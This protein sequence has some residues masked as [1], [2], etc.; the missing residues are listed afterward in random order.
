MS[1]GDEACRM[2]KGGRIMKHIY[3]ERFREGYD[4]EILDNGLEVILW[5]KEGYEKS[6]FM[7]V[8][9]F[10][11]RDL[12]QQD[13]QGKRVHHPQG[14]A[15][16]LEHKMF[17]MHG[18][19]IMNRFSAI[20]ANVNAFTSY[21]ET[22]Y[23]AATCGDPREPLNLLLDFV[24]TLDIDEAS[25]AKEKG[26]ILSELH[27]YQEMSDQQLLRET[28]RSLYQKHP[29][30]YDIG[31]D[32]ASVAATTLAQLYRCYEWNYHPSRMILICISGR[33]NDE[34]RQIIQQNQAQKQFAPPHKRTTVYEAEPESVARPYY[35]FTMDVSNPRLCVAY[36]LKG[37]IDPKERLCC[38]WGIRFLL[39]AY[40]SALNPQYQSWIDT[41]VI[42]DYCGCDVDMGADVGSLLFY[43]ETRQQEAFISLCA[44]CMK[45]IMQGEISQP[46]LIQLRKR[47]Y[48]QSIRAMNNFD[49]MA[50]ALARSRFMGTDYFRML[51]DLDHFQAQDVKRAGAWVSDAQRALICLLPQNY[52]S[53][54][55]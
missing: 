43:G 41:G 12:I 27:M 34:L 53:S 29:L 46:L 35:E 55:L 25:V 19:D 2:S 9:P 15:H 22:A 3:H 42:N 30:R 38:E 26:I 51:D 20:G 40:F 16:F 28:Y 32:D 21:Q 54:N 31:G 5:H 39:D 36:K 18:E 24:Q 11:A 33:N 6:L 48:A 14:I 23:Y 45:R 49:D 1:S 50:I 8:T 17:S 10:G 13:E 37:I 4:Q 47:Y 44:Q 52:G 7:L